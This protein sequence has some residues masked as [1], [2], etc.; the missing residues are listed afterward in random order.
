MRVNKFLAQHT[1]LSR[2]AADT[3]IAEGRVEI[4]SVPAKLGDIVIESDIVTLDKHAVS[5]STDSVVLMLNKPAGYV[6]SRNGQ[7]SKTIYDLL[8]VK[9]HH[10]NPAGRLDKDSSGLLM[11][12]NDGDLANQLTHPRFGKAKVYEVKIDR[13]LSSKHFDQITKTG[14][15]IDG[16]YTSRF[17]IR[18]IH[19]PQSS[20]LNRYEV[21]LAEGKNRQI[22]RTFETLDYKV[23]TLHR[24]A[25]GSYVLEDLKKGEFSVII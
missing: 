20:A 2:R 3:A 9:Y 6:C 13:P 7:G 25:F 15:N 21:T 8:P 12:T 5:T 11:L 14:V 16:E 22:R 18:E 23:K 24:T 4:N 1:S 19:N 17:P 10:L